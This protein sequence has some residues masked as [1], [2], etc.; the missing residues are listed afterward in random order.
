MISH[1]FHILIYKYQEECESDMS[2]I[3]KILP[4]TTQ[5]VALNTNPKVN[6]NIRNETI[7]NLNN[8]NE[9]S[10]VEISDRIKHLNSEWD[11]ER[12]LETNAAL[13]I[14]ISTFLGIKS[15]KYWFLLTSTVGIFLLQHALQG[16]CPPV[17]IIRK[18][19]IRTAEEINNEKTVLKML[20]NDFSQDKS[21]VV[22]MLGIVEK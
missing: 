3:N 5:R 20:R 10:E 18:M 15:C 14:I 1:F 11:T 6:I 7:G 21:Y 22:D 19:R 13:I 8:Y 9:S 4:P 2:S 12:F 16:W 17:P